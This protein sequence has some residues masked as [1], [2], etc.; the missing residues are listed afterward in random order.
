PETDVDDERRREDQLIQ[1]P[2][3]VLLIFFQAVS[4]ECSAWRRVL[5]LGAAALESAPRRRFYGFSL[6]KGRFL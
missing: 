4:A 6:E 1:Q 2:H 3:G 5:Y